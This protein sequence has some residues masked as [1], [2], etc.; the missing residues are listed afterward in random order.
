MTAAPGGANCLFHEQVNSPRLA[1]THQDQAGTG[2]TASELE[3]GSMPWRTAAGNGA[4]KDSDVKFN[5]QFFG[6]GCR[7]NMVSL[8]FFSLGT[9]RGSDRALRGFV[10]GRVLN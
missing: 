2:L 4:H 8:R 1:G 3:N 9:G 5:K 7:P 10:T 6:A